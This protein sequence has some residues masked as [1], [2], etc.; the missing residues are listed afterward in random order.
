M[1]VGARTNY[2]LGRDWPVLGRF[3]ATG[4]GA[5]H[6]RPSRCCCRGGIALLLVAFG[7]LQKAASQAMVEF[8]APVFWFF[9]LLGG[10]VAVRAALSRADDRAAVQGAAVSDLADRVRGDVRLSFLFERHV[11]A[12]QAGRQIALYVMLAGLV[13]WGLLRLTRK[14]LTRTACPLH[15]RRSVLC[16]AA[17]QLLQAFKV[18]TLADWLA[19]AGFFIAWIRLRDVCRTAYTERRARCWQTPTVIGCYG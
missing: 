10:V 13:V 7:A 5:R 9:F 15:C 8:T 14:S 2:A 16:C 18:M 19:L 12:V 17:M 6:V 4:R 3:M 11:C 1:I